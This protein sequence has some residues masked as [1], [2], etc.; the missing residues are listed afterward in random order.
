MAL[1]R[2]VWL[3]AESARC[4]AGHLQRNR[5]QC[6]YR[7]GNK[8]ILQFRPHSTTIA[9]ETAASRNVLSARRLAASRSSSIRPHRPQQ[10]W[11]AGKLGPD[12]A[13]TI[14]ACISSR[15][16][17]VPP[18]NRASLARPIPAGPA[19]HPYMNDFWPGL[20]A[21]RRKFGQPLSL[22][23]TPRSDSD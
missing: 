8:R 4:L 12:V 21:P 2:D 9:C 11:P 7:M 16:S 1:I 19:H 13:S 15:V 22:T 10:R 14:A 23:V 5:L 6:L 17:N 20:N 18:P 3:S